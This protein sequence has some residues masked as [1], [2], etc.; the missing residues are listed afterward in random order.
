[1]TPSI[2]FSK[3]SQI[4]SLWI[5]L[6]RQ[7]GRSETKQKLV[8]KQQLFANFIKILALGDCY[9]SV[10]DVQNENG[11]M[12][13]FDKFMNSCLLYKNSLCLLI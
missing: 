4:P 8:S 5:R 1:M 10:I 9:C 7:R 3:I 13:T 12:K 6:F 2:I 11:N